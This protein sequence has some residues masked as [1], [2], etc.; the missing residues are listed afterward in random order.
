MT[1]RAGVV[2]L[3]VVGAV[4]SSTATTTPASPTLTTSA[5]VADPQ[6]EHHCSDK[7]TSMCG[8][9]VL[10]CLFDK[11]CN[12]TMRPADLVTQSCECCRECIACLGPYLT[13]C[14]ACVG[15]CEL[16][17]PSSDDVDVEAE[18]AEEYD[19]EIEHFDVVK[20]TLGLFEKTFAPMVDKQWQ[21]YTFS[22]VEE[23]GPLGSRL[24]K[25]VAQSLAAP[26][27]NCTV[28]YLDEC[29]SRK[30]C[31]TKCKVLMASSF[32]WF[33]TGC[34]EC[35]GEHCLAGGSTRARCNH[36]RH[37]DFPQIDEEEEQ[38]VMGIVPSQLREL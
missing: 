37:E 27:P 5:V 8:P 9:R 31:A 25:E 2:L 38:E 7:P 4:L 11:S 21:M 13:E 20:E 23:P 35:A 22:V 29:V 28:V 3:I 1:A 17:P 15:L 18:E 16:S 26:A 10:K 34:C 19:Y 24:E 33:V 36:C 6:K 14:C 12:C 30:N 32:R